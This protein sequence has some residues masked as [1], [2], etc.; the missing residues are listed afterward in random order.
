MAELEPR[1]RTAVA[2]VLAVAVVAAPVL[3][4]LLAADVSAANYRT[5]VSGS[6]ATSSTTVGNA[7]APVPTE[8]TVV[9][10]APEPV[11]PHLERQV[12]E[13]FAAEGLDVTVAAEIPDGDDPVVVVVVDEWDARWNPVTPSATVEWRA[14]YDANGHERHVEAALAENVVVFDSRDGPDVVASGDYRLDDSATGLV[15]RPAYRR[16]LAAS[17]AEETAQRVVTEI[18]RERAR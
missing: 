17:V 4:A 1:A 3:G 8:A 9:V 7:S 15:S 11:R 2:L 18:R 10:R 5:Q 13:A 14:V 12:R 16:H 6:T